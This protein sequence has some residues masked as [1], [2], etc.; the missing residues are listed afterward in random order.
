M[1][2]QQ[3]FDDLARLTL[4]I[5]LGLSFALAH[6]WPKLASFAERAES[7]PDPLGIGSTPSLVLAI[8]GELVCGLAVALGLFT[9]WT[10]VAP[11]VTMVVAFFLVHAG[12]PFGNRELALLYLAGFVA[13]LLLGGGRWSLDRL[14]HR[15]KS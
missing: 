3:R 8:F 11:I 1:A 14:I 4:R 7:F 13:I 12:D 2:R 10:V 9:R 15:R 5:V 6:G